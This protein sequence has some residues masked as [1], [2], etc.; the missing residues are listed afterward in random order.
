MDIKLLYAS[1]YDSNIDRSAQFF[2]LEREKFNRREKDHNY[3]E[4]K[5]GKFPKTTKKVL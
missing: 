3:N 2:W 4:R 1:D 5:Y